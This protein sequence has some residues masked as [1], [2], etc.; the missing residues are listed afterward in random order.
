MTKS[1][2]REDYL[3]EIERIHTAI[4]ANIAE[5][6]VMLGFTYDKALLLAEDSYLDILHLLHAVP[7]KA[8]R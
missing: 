8:H 4:Q 5:Y 1:N 6:A 2:S 3:E 7:F